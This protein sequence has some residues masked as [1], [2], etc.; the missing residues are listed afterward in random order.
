MQALRQSLEQLRQQ[1]AGFSTTAKLSMAALMIILIM[2]LGYVVM[3]TAQSEFVRLNLAA[4]T[5]ED[6]RLQ[7]V[8]Y[9]RDNNIEHRP[10]GR[11]IMVPADEMLPL[12]GRLQQDQVIS[13]DEV[14]FASFVSEGSIFED[15]QTRERRYLIGKMR[16]A[17]AMLLGM[18]G[19]AAARVVID[20]PDRIQGFGANRVRESA[21]VTVRPVKQA[22]DHRVAESIALLVSGVQ[23]GLDAKDVQ[24]IDA[25]TNR[26]F[27]FEDDSLLGSD[28]LYERKRMV[29]KDIRGKIE[30][31]L[32]HIPGAIVEVSAD[33][34]PNRREVHG[35]SVEDPKQGVLRDESREATSSR[36]QPVNEAGVRANTG[37][38]VANAQNTASET[39]NR[40]RSDL[41]PVFPN[42]RS[43]TVMPAGAVK[44]V[45]ASVSL[46]RSELTR[47][48]RERSGDE[49]A[50]PT[51][52]DE[53][54]WVE[55]V[56]TKVRPI[57]GGTSAGVAGAVEVTVHDGGGM[58]A[59]GVGVGGGAAL[60]A[61]D[62]V[63][64][65]ISRLLEGGG[66]IS[67]VMLGLLALVSLGLM[68]MVVRGA[69]REEELPTPEE[70]LGIPPALADEGAH[71]V[72]EAGE[73][74]IAL[75]G[76]EVDESVLQHEQML[77]QVN[78]SAHQAPADVAS[79]LRRWIGEDEF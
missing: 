70:I 55:G 69:G 33:L 67:T 77:A 17:E 4:T 38:T 15:R 43:L 12:L 58:L 72:G 54:A 53:Q 3:F 47:M 60:L 37:T 66:L 48:V 18:D 78:Q 51:P 62:G 71:V 61:K 73:T 22:L 39:Q 30:R 24:V 44:S 29:E 79:V 7:V 6:T 25:S 19:I 49:E 28:R 27:S 46:P 5:D 74:D 11:E 59:S 2:G 31:L 65:G 20:M 8:Q 9:L 26:A 10:S 64:G 13:S 23:S 76:H 36:Q 52:E 45:S 14:D 1:L 50:V 56:R 40:T 16:A 35:L 32:V 21:S 34:D 42:E 68:F 57:L 63:G 41:V 75:V